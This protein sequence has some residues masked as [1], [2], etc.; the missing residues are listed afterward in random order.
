[1]SPEDPGQVAGG[2]RRYGL[3]AGML[4]GALAAAGLLTYGFFALAS[5]SLPAEQYGVIV[6]LWS[7]VFI[8]VSTL[9]R[10]VE[11]LLSR[12]IAELDAHGQGIGRAVRVAASIQFALAATLVVVAFAFKDPITDELLDERDFLFGVMVTAVVAF[13]FEFFLRGFL[14]GSR[15]FNVFAALLLI[16]GCGRLAFSLAVA[17]GI[18]EGVD[19]VALGIVAGPTLSL[20]VVPWAI[21]GRLAAAQ[22]APV[23]DPAPAAAAPDVP[24]FTLARGGGFA[25]A[26]LV[27]MLSEQVFLNGGPLFVRAEAGAAA[28]GF[29]FN[30]L[31]VARA[32]V[33]LFQAVA[34]SLLP[35]LTRLRSTGDENS[36]QTF[37]LSIRMTIRVVAAVAALVVVVILIGGPGLMQIAFGDEFSYDRAG[38]AIVA[39]GMGFYLSAGTLNQAALAQGQARRAA[40]CWAICAVGFI[41]WNLAQPLDVYRTVEVG[42]LG[43]A[44]MLCTLLYLVYRSPH[45]RAGDELEPGSARELEAQLAAA[46]EAG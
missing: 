36:D 30:V 6:V 45:P 9:F 18:A 38:L 1:M 8:L 44:V 22:A 41:V 31:M 19:V 37:R 32:P 20:L 5:H 7:V 40:T 15:R 23:V 39:V 17:I 28:A 43:V 26:V 46:D 27:M 2:A 24:Q 14:A 29:I 11:Q 12:T 16:D 33:V 25:A 4:T 10:P 3:T 42:F 13:A 21:R 34:A 35:H